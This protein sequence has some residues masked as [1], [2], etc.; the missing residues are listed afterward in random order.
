MHRNW[1]VVAT[2]WP[3]N[4]VQ[5]TQGDLSGSASAVARRTN[6]TKS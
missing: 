2:G 5:L 3:R 6:R 4:L 1:F